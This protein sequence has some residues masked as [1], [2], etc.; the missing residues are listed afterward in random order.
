VKHLYMSIRRPG[1]TVILAALALASALPVVARAQAYPAK[2]IRW[3]VPYTPAGAF[4]AISRLVAEKVGIGLGQQVVVEN[5]PGADGA[6]GLDMVAK[7]AP[8]GYTVAIG[9]LPTHAINPSLFRK[10]PYDHMRDFAPVSMLGSAAVVLLANPTAPMKTAGD[11]VAYARANPGKVSY[12]SSGAGMHLSMEMLRSA[13]GI[14]VV[15][16][17]Y[18][19]SSP[20]LVDLIAGQVPVSIDSVPASLQFIRSGRVRALA[21]GSAKRARLLPEVPTLIESGIAVEST[22]WYA[23]FVPAGVPR[24]VVDRLNAEVVKAMALDDVV[25]R[26]AETGIEAASSSPTELGSHVRAESA[27]WAKTIRES[28]I[29][30]Q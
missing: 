18:K 5:R 8:D 7:S 28:G 4:D 10:L 20:A 1:R 9:G 6:I 14:N 22:L 21:V 17:P 15:Q 13:T 12:A 30:L 23:L 16:V 19:G 29:E 25:R 2:P 27:K 24:P 26:L 3:I 11:F